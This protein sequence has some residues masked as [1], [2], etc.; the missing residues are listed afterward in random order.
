MAA[1]GGGEAAE[2]AARESLELRFA[3]ATPINQVVLQ[4]EIAQGERVRE[5]IVQVLTHERWEGVYVGTAIGH[6]KIDRFPTIAAEAV[7][8]HFRKVEEGARLKG[9]A[10][11]CG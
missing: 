1:P 2:Q 11:Y 8:V 9:I 5:Y 10:A 6:K 4:E 7:R 3:E